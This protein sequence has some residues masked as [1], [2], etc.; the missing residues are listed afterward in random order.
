MMLFRSLPYIT[1]FKVA[2]EVEEDF[3]WSHLVVVVDGI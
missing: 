3:S 2:S 1:I